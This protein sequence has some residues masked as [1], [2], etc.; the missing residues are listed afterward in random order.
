MTISVGL[1][2]GA[3][4]EELIKLISWYDAI[5]VQGRHVVNIIST[6]ITRDNLN[7]VRFNLFLT[8]QLAALAT[9]VVRQ[10][11]IDHSIHMTMMTLS[12]GNI[13]R[14]TGH[15][16]REFTDDQWIPAQNQWRGAFMFSLICFSI[17]G[18]VNNGEAGDFRRHRAHYDVTVMR[19]RH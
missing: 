14:V 2:R 16:C 9:P 6:S 3:V 11:K 1:H 13:F 5:F 7:T 17:N 12:N 8:W 15:L 19:I 18:W 4:S 10:A